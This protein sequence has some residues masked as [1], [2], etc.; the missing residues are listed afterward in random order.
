MKTYLIDEEVLRQVLDALERG[1][2]IA[3]DRNVERNLHI[4]IVNAFEN[5]RAIL[6]SPPTEPVAWLN[7]NGEIWNTPVCPYK[8]ELGWPLFR[9]DL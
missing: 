7:P 5:L 1:V 8:H 2:D 3:S 6:A 9:K 4:P